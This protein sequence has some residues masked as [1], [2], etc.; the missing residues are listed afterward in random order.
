M[1]IGFDFE[2][3]LSYEYALPRMGAALAQ[4]WPQTHYISHNTTYQRVGSRRDSDF[5]RSNW[6]QKSSA[7]VRSCIFAMA[8]FIEMDYELF[9][10]VPYSADSFPRD[11]FK[12]LS[13]KESLGGVKLGWNH[14]SNKKAISRSSKNPIAWIR[15]YNLRIVG[16][17]LKE[18]TW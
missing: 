16:R 3:S 14:S 4:H 15:S 12:L 10:H 17:N 11:Y 9:P 1:L 8:K 2:W 6:C 7:R 5:F 18:T 13:L